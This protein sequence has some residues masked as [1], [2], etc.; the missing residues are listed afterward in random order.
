MTKEDPNLQMSLI[1]RYAKSYHDALSMIENEV[2]DLIQ[3]GR[4]ME[5]LYLYVENMSKIGEVHKALTKMYSLIYRSQIVLQHYGSKRL[6]Q[7]G[8]NLK[9]IREL[10]DDPG[11]SREEIENLVLKGIHE[12]GVNRQSWLFNTCFL[13]ELEYMIKV[14]GILIEPEFVPLLKSEEDNKEE[15]SNS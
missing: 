15:K 14:L 12:A 11:S 13:N 8:Y 5:G 9:P 10:I 7:V 2:K 1:D 3:K 4:E 6:Q